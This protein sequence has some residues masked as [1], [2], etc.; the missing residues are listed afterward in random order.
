MRT[1]RNVF[2]HLFRTLCGTDTPHLHFR[3][4][5]SKPHKTELV[6]SVFTVVACIGKCIYSSDTRRNVWTFLGSYAKIILLSHTRFSDKRSYAML[7]LKFLGLWWLCRGTSQAY[8]WCRRL[9]FHRDLHVHYLRPT[10][11]SYRTT[12]MYVGFN[13]KSHIICRIFMVYSFV[14]MKPYVMYV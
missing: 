7:H 2:W 8:C 11:V 6:K 5:I 4:C 9:T 1:S 3:I 12:D 13:L 10:N 14:H